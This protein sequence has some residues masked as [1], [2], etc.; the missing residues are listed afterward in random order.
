MNTFILKGP[1][2]ELE[3]YQHSESPCSHSRAS[4]ILISNRKF[5]FVCCTLCNW[6]LILQ[7]VWFLLLNIMVLRFIHVVACNNSSFTVTYIKESVIWAY[8]SLSTL[9]LKGIWIGFSKVLSNLTVNILILVF[10]VEHM[11]A[12]LLGIIIW[13]GK[14]VNI[15]KNIILVIYNYW[16]SQKIKT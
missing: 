4:T 10:F 13:W 7:C 12:F 2:Q 6:I 11:P 3:H 16:F 8:H 1:Y 5:N 15:C 14:Y 9:L